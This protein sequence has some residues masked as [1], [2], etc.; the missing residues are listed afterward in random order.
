[1]TSTPCGGT[2]TGYDIDF[3]GSVEPLTDGLL[4]LRY[5]FGF[6]GSS[7]TLGALGQNAQRT[8]PAAIIAYLDCVR[9]DILDPDGSG[10]AEPLTDGLL[11]LRYFFEFRD[12]V[13]IASAVDTD[14]CVRCLADEIEAYIEAILSG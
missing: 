12:A 9:P 10:V 14:N 7:L 8:D 11:L 2:Y 13:L 5:L 3:N 6:T 1:V 4:I